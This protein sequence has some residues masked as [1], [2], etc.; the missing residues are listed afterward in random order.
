LDFELLED[1][2]LNFSSCS[3]GQTFNVV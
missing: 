3:T 1:R 2:E